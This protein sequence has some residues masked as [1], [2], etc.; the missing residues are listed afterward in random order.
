MTSPKIL[1]SKASSLIFLAASKEKFIEV[2]KTLD[3]QDQYSRRNCLLV[4]GADENNNKDTDQPD[5]N[6]I[7]NDLGEEITINDINKRNRLGKRRLDNNV[8]RPIINKFVSETFVIGFS[9]LKKRK[10][11]EHY[12]KSNKEKSN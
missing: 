12:G 6:I 7:K 10:N 3:R 9:N 1:E 2:D 5:T 8:P 4:H 11:R